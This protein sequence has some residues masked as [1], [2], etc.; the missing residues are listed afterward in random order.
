[1]AKQKRR[2]AG[3]K[4]TD[5]IPGWVHMSAGLAIGLAVAYGIY[6]SDRRQP[7]IPMPVAAETQP[8]EA[9]TPQEVVEI[10]PPENE[11]AIT[12]DFYDMLP[13][14]DV[15]LYDNAAAAQP[16]AQHQLQP[17][18]AA[19]P[20]APAVAPAPTPKP[21]PVVATVQPA[22]KLA[23]SPAPITAA[24]TPVAEKPGIYIL[25]AGSFSRLEVAQKRKAEVTELG[26]TAELK[27]GTVN[28]KTVY[29]VYTAPLNNP[30][31]V[32]RVRTLLIGVGIDI[33]QKRVSD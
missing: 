20:P 29:R 31:D 30:Q 2:K 10:I 28:G 5:S 13:N 7:S 6:V 19:Q 1:M 18:L 11:T 12:F 9:V 4:Q 33:L 25:Q 17:A 27:R 14:L 22:V 26:V 3:K 16:R 24:A 32:N 15:D 23:P 8:E 21:P